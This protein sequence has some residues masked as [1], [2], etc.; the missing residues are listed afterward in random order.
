MLP[1]IRRLAPEFDRNTRRVLITH[2]DVD[3]CGLLPLFDEIIASPKSAECL[4]LEAAGEDGFRERNVL[5]KP[6]IRICKVLT[7]Y[8]TVAPERIT[9]P[10][11]DAGEQQEA[12]RQI[13]LF[14]FGDLHFEVY[15]GKGGHLPGEIVLIDYE[16]HVVFTGDVYVNLKGMTP[17]QAKYNQY[18]PILMTSVDTDAALCAQ[19]RRAVMQR[20][21]AGE[22]KIFGA[23]GAMKE[24]ELKVV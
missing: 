17:E 22:W 12:L 23:H 4:R 24:Y 10:W 5:H 3:H 19:E 18:A 7:G 2:A 6:Y 9:V 20:L 16:H 14:D 8:G 1:L 13:G 11:T 15:E 21:G